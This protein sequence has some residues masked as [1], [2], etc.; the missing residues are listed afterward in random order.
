M[1]QEAIDAAAAKLRETPRQLARM[2]PPA[3]D[4]GVQDRRKIVETFITLIDG[5]YAHLPLKR[6]MHGHDPVQRLRL[7]QQRVAAVDEATFHRTIAEILTDLRDAH[8]RYIGPGSNRGRIAVLPLL[9]E[10]YTEIGPGVFPNRHQ[11]GA[12][13]RHATDHELIKDGGPNHGTIPDIQC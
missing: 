8:T 11:R 7:L 12:R 10:A 5:L 1:T 2:A 9:V 4:L 13:R 6:A 3:R